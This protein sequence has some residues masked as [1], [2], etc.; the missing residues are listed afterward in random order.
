MIRFVYYCGGCD[1]VAEAG[2]VRQQF[3]SFSGRGY[4]FGAYRVIADPVMDAPDGWVAF[5]L[6]GATYC[7]GCAAEIW[8]ES[9]AIDAA[10]GG[11]G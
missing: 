6:I 3:E 9:A 1:N 2:H 10:R 8:P 7:P 4:G 5:D 11:E